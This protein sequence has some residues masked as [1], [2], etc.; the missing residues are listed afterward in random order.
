MDG[1]V[2]ETVDMTQGMAEQMPV[3]M[4]EP[5]GEGM[6]AQPGLLDK[7]KDTLNPNKLAQRFDKDTLM[8]MGMYLGVGF[9][10]GFLLKKYFNYVLVFALGIAGILGLQ[11]LGV[12]SIGID[13]MRMQEVFGIKQAA[14]LDSSLLASYWDWIRLNVRLVVSFCSGF[15]IGLKLG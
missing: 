8:E 1:M 6:M 4:A 3:E 14:A 15:L 2:V 10:S 5:M 11:H 13:W 12:I 7:I 9:L